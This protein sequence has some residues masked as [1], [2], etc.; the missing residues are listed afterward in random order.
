MVLVD[1][2]EASSKGLRLG[3]MVKDISK[4]A[5]DLEDQ[6]RVTKV[7]VKDL[8]AKDLMDQAREDH[9]DSRD[10]L[11]R[12][13]ETK[14][15]KVR[16]SVRAHIRKIEEHLVREDIV[17]TSSKAKGLMDRVRVDQ[18]VKDLVNK[19][20]IAIMVIIKDP[21]VVKEVDIIEALKPSTRM[22]MISQHTATDPNQ[23]EEGL[24]LK[25]LMKEKIL[26]KRFSTKRWLRKMITE[27]IETE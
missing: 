10:V 16:I 7:K 8:G 13:I 14:G 26:I 19:D 15:H 27:E 4:E 12:E 2:L 1:H 11:I 24:G 3:L 23:L 18:L 9:R 25:D 20:L 6:G 17:Q 22:R 21:R 5:K